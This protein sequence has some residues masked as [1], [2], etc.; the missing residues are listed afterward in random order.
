MELL[1]SAVKGG[2]PVQA[3]EFGWASFWITLYLV[4][5]VLLFVAAQRKVALK[6]SGRSETPKIPRSVLQCFTS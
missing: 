2:R 5:A 6:A 3:S 4:G 1:D